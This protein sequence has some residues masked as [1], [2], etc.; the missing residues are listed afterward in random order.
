MGR[1][2]IR[3]RQSLFLLLALSA[4]PSLARA[5]WAGNGNV[6]CTAAGDQSLPAIASDGAGGAFVVWVDN[7][8]VANGSDLFLQRILSTGAI[9]SG[10]TANGIPLV[11]DSNEQDSPAIVP[12]GAGGVFVAWRDD[13]EFGT[14]NIYLQR[15]TGAGAPAAGW[16]ANGIP[17]CEALGDQTVPVLEQEAGSAIVTWRDARNATADIYAQ[18]VSGAGVVQWAADGVPVCA[19]AG[20]QTAPTIAPDQSGGAIIA[21]ED[22]RSGFTADIYAQRLNASGAA[23]WM[24]DGIALCD[25]LNDQTTPYA[26]PDASGGAIVVWDDYRANN[27]NIYAQ[28]VNGAGVAQWAAGGVALCADPNEQYGGLPVSDGA[29]GAIVPWIDFRFAAASLFAQ[30]ISAA[31]AIGWAV[32]GLAVTTTGDVSDTPVASPDGTGGAFFVWDDDARAGS[33][34]VY[35]VRITANGGVGSGW[36]AGG[37]SICNSAGNQFLPVVTTDGTGSLIASWIDARNGNNDVYAKRLGQSPA[38]DVPLATPASLALAAAPNPMES[39]VWLRFTLPTAQRVG[40]Q[41]LDVTGRVARTLLEGQELPAGPGA[42]QWDGK[43]G[44][45]ALAPAGLYFAR[46]K[47][48][49]QTEV[50]AIARLR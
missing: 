23:Q 24:A 40:L 9:A 18:K 20:F 21:W 2:R 50:R 39:H 12:D 19:A 28:R 38:V 8:T 33:V 36:S 30:K 29:G 49:T 42:A 13:R 35:A 6:I 11:V 45:G 5:Q 47:T 15:I 48:A 34:D 41:I 22:K 31:G 37:N 44:A 43:D 3:I 1:V 7:R 26:I 10:W 46:L 25:S 14:S 27:S 4:F 16:P 17:V 32:N